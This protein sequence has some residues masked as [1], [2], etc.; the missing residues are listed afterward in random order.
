MFKTR[1]RVTGF[2]FACAMFMMFFMN[3]IDVEASAKA[4]LDGF[5]S[6]VA[7][8]LD[9]TNCN[10]KEAKA[11][12]KVT[13]EITEYELVME[14][15]D[16]TLNVRLE[17]SEDS[18]IVGMLY[19]DCGGTILERQDGWTKF[20]SGS[21]IGWAKDEYLL[22]GDAAI[23]LANLV[24][25]PVAFV[26]SDALR[27]RAT[28]TLEGEVLGFVSEGEGLSII[29]EIDEMWLCVE[30]NDTKG[31]V[32]REYVREEFNIDS[33]ETYDQITDRKMKEEADKNSLEKYYDSMSA[34]EYELLLLA[35][36]I[37]C[38]AGGESYEGQVAVGAVVLNRVRSSKYPNSVYGVIYASGQFTPALTGK[39]D[40]V[41]ISGKATQSC[42]NAAKE[43]LNGY[44]NVGD[45]LYFRVNNGSREG[46][47]LGNHVFY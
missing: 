21:L 47:V 26:T 1:P 40:A 12:V 30:Y 39:L 37:Y 6:G 9:P 22:F 4:Q 15:V 2:V 11:T 28:A 38:E 46:Y 3:V 24:G 27:I 29:E 42:Y 23:E 31:Y 32:Q 25:Y 20:Q 7:A 16:S 41:M 10:T 44:T 19:N 17:P 13:G 35:S 43:A 5:N 18:E 14:N 34:S 45:S 36:L 8:I 33:G